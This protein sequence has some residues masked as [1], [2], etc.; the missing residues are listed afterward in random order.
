[1][2]NIKTKSASFLKANIPSEM[3]ALLSLTN[4]KQI[5]QLRESIA[6]QTGKAVKQDRILGSIGF[7]ISKNINSRLNRPGKNPVTV[8]EFQDNLVKLV[9]IIQTYQ[10][11]KQAAIDKQERLDK[12]GVRARDMRAREVAL[13]KMSQG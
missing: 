6:Q 7:D 5:K 4:S 11:V 9:E 12:P 2:G 8:K 3:K 13:R 10:D 1:M